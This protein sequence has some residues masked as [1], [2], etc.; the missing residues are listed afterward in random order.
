MDNQ[1][2][3]ARERAMHFR[4]I[5]AVES[6]PLSERQEA[7]KAWAEALILEP[8]TVA[9][10]IGWILNGS[11]GYGS[12]M[13]SRQIMASPR[14]NQGAALAQMVAALEWRCPA[15]FAREAYRKLTDKQRGIVDA[16]IA[17]ELKDYRDEQAAETAEASNG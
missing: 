14:M 8:G 9:E 17:D 7:R 1:A 2:Y 12:Y 6:A 15:T 5:L 13:L 10:R 16:A 3:E 4:D 11:Y